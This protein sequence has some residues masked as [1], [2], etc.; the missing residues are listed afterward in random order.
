MTILEISAIALVALLVL[1]PNAMRSLFRDLWEASDM[2]SQYAQHIQ[3]QFQMR[4]DTQSRSD[5][6]FFGFLLGVGIVWLTLLILSV[7]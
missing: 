1:G 6:V 2:L 3:L 5:G 4:L 7:S